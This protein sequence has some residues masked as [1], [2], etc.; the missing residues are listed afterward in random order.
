MRIMRFDPIW[1]DFTGYK[2]TAVLTLNAH[3]IT[4]SA[5]KIG[6]FADLRLVGSDGTPEAS[7]Y[8]GSVES[9]VRTIVGGRT[10]MG[11]ELELRARSAAAR[12]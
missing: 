12:T 9:F 11:F 1:D 6:T 3:S 2:Y 7:V 10:Q 5:T 8:N 4:S